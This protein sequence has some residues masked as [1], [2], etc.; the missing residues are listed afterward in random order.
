MTWTYC[1][2]M[3]PVST[4]PCS[5]QQNLFTPLPHKR[6]LRYWIFFTLWESRLD[7]PGRPFFA[8]FQ[9][10]YN[11]SRNPV[12]KWGKNETRHDQMA[13]VFNRKKQSVKLIGYR[14]CLN[15]TIQKNWIQVI[16]TNRNTLSRIIKV[17]IIEVSWL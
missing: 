4:P 17:F 5:L 13:P 7:W 10:C 1:T 12:L 14:R 16:F 6:R 8:T 15:R 9:L 11:I 3:G 2:Y